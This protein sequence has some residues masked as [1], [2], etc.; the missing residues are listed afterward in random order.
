MRYF[1]GQQPPFRHLPL[2]PPPSLPKCL[3]GPSFDVPGVQQKD[4]VVEVMPPAAADPH[5][6]LFIS[7][8]RPGETLREGFKLI[9]GER[10]SGQQTRIIVLPSWVDAQQ[11]KVTGLASG[12]L[13]IT[14]PRCA[15]GPPPA[16]ARRLAI[17]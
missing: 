2:T 5:H 13:T 1:L 16:K 10:W 9:K 11:V 7:V 14:A 15:G 4:I 17:A 12:S 6:K 8:T 3:W